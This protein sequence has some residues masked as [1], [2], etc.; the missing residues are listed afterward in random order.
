VF[1]VLC[2]SVGWGGESGNGWKM[3][4]GGC[5]EEDEDQVDDDGGD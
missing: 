5:R 1:E 3:V 2:L 4:G